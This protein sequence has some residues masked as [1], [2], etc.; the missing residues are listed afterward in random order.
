[1]PLKNAINKTK[2]AFKRTKNHYPKAINGRDHSTNFNEKIVV[3]VG[4]N[5][6]DQWGWGGVFFL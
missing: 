4:A 5:R 2:H 1:M 6:S 3:F